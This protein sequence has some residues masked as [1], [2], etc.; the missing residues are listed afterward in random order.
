MKFA[1]HLWGNAWDIVYMTTISVKR[2]KKYLPLSEIHCQLE[3]SAFQ[4]KC[5]P[6]TIYITTSIHQALWGQVNSFKK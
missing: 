1:T 5:L 4:N 2:M 3:T 6:S